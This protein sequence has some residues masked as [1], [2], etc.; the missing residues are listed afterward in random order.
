MI[1]P[2][3]IAMLLLIAGGAHALLGSFRL[4]FLSRANIL[5]LA[6]VL[7]GAALLHLGLVILGDLP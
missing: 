3:G 6:L 2:I 5:P 1:T 7:I 4:L